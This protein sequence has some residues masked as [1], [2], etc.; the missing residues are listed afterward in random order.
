MRRGH[1]RG[2]VF[3][4]TSPSG[5]S[6]WYSERSGA[7]LTA[8]SL[9]AVYHLAAGD[10]HRYRRGADR[11]RRDGVQVLVEDRHIGEHARRE[12]AGQVLL[13]VYVRH[14]LGESLDRRVH[15]DRL[16]GQQGLA[17]GRCSRL[18]EPAGNYPVDRHVHL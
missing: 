9:A 7:T 14:A 3:T 8:S 2:Y 10:R 5:T 18:A 13:V 12:R 6:P 17:G 4:S 15:G 16:C 11:V 1:G